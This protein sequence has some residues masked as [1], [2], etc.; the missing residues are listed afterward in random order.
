MR[1]HHSGA[2]IVSRVFLWRAAQRD[3]TRERESATLG[4]EADLSQLA[5][6]LLEQGPTFRTELV[7]PV[8]VVTGLH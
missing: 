7:L 8:G 2:L 3:L 4:I 5:R 6:E 1:A